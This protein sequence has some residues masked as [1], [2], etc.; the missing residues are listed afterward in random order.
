MHKNY[1]DAWNV[2]VGLLAITVLQTVDGVEVAGKFTL[3]WGVN[4]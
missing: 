3:C 1:R 2:S 4:A